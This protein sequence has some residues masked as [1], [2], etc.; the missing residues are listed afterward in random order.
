[1]LN[2]Q[3][4]PTP[5]VFRDWKDENRL[6]YDLDNSDNDFDIL[7][8][9]AKEAIQHTL[10][11]EQSGLCCYCMANISKKEEHV[12]VN[13]R[14]KIKN[15]FD[16]KVEH[17]LC[18][19]EHKESKFEYSNFLCACKGE[20][21]KKGNV[22]KH[23]DSKK[24]SK[25]LKFNP[26]QDDVESIITYKPNGEI[27][28]T[29]EEFDKELETVLNLNNEFLKNNRREVWKSVPKLFTGKEWTAAQLLKK[30]TDLE[31]K[32]GQAKLPAYA[33]VI[34]FYLKR[35]LKSKQ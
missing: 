14:A 25:K 29:D 19:H 8:T 6:I 3:K 22:T 11:A 4:K 2:I 9:A 30:I 31:V 7:S 26:S 10:Y 24:L 33:G 21:G 23:C 20:I 17:F 16:M 5:K 1:M 13:G 12:T 34:L 35:K 28:S 27:N 18:Q 15:S 32:K